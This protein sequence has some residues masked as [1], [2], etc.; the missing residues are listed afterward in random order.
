MRVLK[1]PSALLPAAMLFLTVTVAAAKDAP[2]TDCRILTQYWPLWSALSPHPW[3]D[4]DIRERAFF[5]TQEILA[6]LRAVPLDKPL[7]VSFGEGQQY[8]RPWEPKPDQLAAYAEPAFAYELGYF[9]QAIS[10]FDKVVKDTSSPFRAA[11]AYSAA[12][13]SFRA[14]MFDE[15]VRR[16]DALLRDETLSEFEHAAAT[17]IGRMRYGTSALP[18][19]AARLAEVSRFMTAPTAAICPPDRASEELTK[20]LPLTLQGYE[21]ILK[22][23]RAAEADIWLADETPEPDRDQRWPLPHYDRAAAAMAARDPV[24]DALAALVAPWPYH[25]PGQA[26]SRDA[27]LNPTLLDHARQQW[28]KSRNPLW[29]LAVAE[30][31]RD[32]AD[33]AVIAEAVT[34]VRAWPGLTATA[35]A[36]LTWRLVAQ[37][38]RILYQAGRA[39]EGIAALDSLTREDRRALTRRD[40]VPDIAT[41]SK[42]ILDDGV[43]WFVARADLEAARHWAITVGQATGIPVSEE[44]KP[45]LAQSVDDLYNHPIVGLRP[46]DG[47]IELGWARALFDLMPPKALVEFARHPRLAPDDRRALVGAAI[48]Q[49][50]AQRRWA[51]IRAWLP[52]LRLAQPSLAPDIDRIERTWWPPKQRHLITMLL[53][54]NPGLVARPSWARPPGGEDH[55]SILTDS[56]R[57]GPARP[58]DWNAF[59]RENPR[60]GNWWCS[61]DPAV[62]RSEAAD[63]LIFASI[64]FGPYLV[65]DIDAAAREALPPPRSSDPNDP[66]WKQSR[67]AEE[68]QKA[69]VL[70]V[71]PLLKPM[72]PQTPTTPGRWGDASERL[73]KD[74][75]AWARD[76]GVVT[77]W[78]EGDDL[79]AEALHRAVMATRYSCRVDNGPWSRAAYQELHRRF[80][81]S[82]WS[83]KTPY[84]FGVIQ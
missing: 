2:P 64:P 15:G 48:A 52:D 39:D 40:R 13:A 31:S 54:R 63:S 83:A 73:T 59:D 44:L 68:Q 5:P 41:A 24:I 10:G 78:L 38:V 55:Y 16:I 80:S 47:L 61:A 43:R 75:L 70:A 3:T 7:P 23:R 21:T 42:T 4:E 14:G 8:Y 74:V 29:A 28:R 49:A 34:A 1:A 50:Y 60:D 62:F 67:Q 26:G 82:P 77:R 9:T 45:A 51:D 66:Y 32:P 20:P 33:G 18:L 27:I 84:W 57:D 36:A 56:L 58:G 12:R 19:A 17:L 11:A 53:L 65:F 81:H 35:R 6:A 76:E 22:L 46:V 69:K 79:L 72:D 37:R 25:T 71:I 30:H